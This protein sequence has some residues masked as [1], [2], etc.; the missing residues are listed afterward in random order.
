MKYAFIA[1]HRVQFSVWTRHRLLRVHPIEFYAWLKKPLRRRASE[2]ETQANFLQ[3]TCEQS[4]KVRGCRKL[5]DDLWGQGTI[6]C[7]RRPGIYGGMTDWQ[8]DIVALYKEWT[9]LLRRHNL[10]HLISRRGNCHDD[11]AAE[12]L[13]NILKR[14]RIQ[15]RIY[16]LAMKLAL[17][18]SVPSKCS[19]TRSANMSGTG[20]CYPSNPRR[21]CRNLTRGCLQNPEPFNTG[22]PKC[23]KASGTQLT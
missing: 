19:T 6:C 18:C 15:R 12:S 3:R 2:D 22:S 8:P 17:T 16:V 7:K 23:Q 13:F 9:S 4:G 10:V 1:L 20:C 14:V 11:V 5:H 21:G